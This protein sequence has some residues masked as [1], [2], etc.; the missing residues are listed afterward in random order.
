VPCGARSGLPFFAILST[1]GKKAGDSNLLPGGRNI[2]YPAQPDEIAAFQKLL[3]Q[4][5]PHLTAEQLSHL[6]SYLQK[7]VAH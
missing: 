7:P 2:G 3:K 1:E 6:V 4:T 5:A